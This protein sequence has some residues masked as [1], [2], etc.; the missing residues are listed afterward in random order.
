VIVGK[1]DHIVLKSLELVF[2]RN[3]EEYGEVRSRSPKMLL[4]EYNG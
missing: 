2:R 4:E 1:P 3:F